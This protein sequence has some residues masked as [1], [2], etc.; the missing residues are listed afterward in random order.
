MDW[1][2]SEEAFS[3]GVFEVSDL[4]DDTHEFNDEDASDD[5]E[6]DFVSGYHGAISDG[7]TQG[8]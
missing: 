8:K 2:A 6:Q 5:E 3:A 7:G 4:E 1:R